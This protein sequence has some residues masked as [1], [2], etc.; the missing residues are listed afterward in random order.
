ME[1]LKQ[2]LSMDI[3]E[4]ASFALSG[5]MIGVKKKL[6]FFG[7]VISGVVTATG[8]GMMRDILLG[9]I[10]PMAFVDPRYVIA[11]AITSA[12]LFLIARIKRE[13]YVARADLVDQ[14]N[15]VVDAL[16]LGAFTVIGVQSVEAAGYGDN[17]FFSIFIGVITA[18]GGGALRD[19]FLN[20][21][22]FILYKRVYMVAS[23]LGAAVYVDLRRLGFDESAATLPVV[24]LV[25]VV[26][27]LAT[28]YHWDFPKAIE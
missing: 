24:I 12:I 23:M 10:P 25:F 6:D 1:I 3:L 22:P 11:A 9:K 15:N 21:M 28:R 18:V 20:E 16:G 2:Y 27:M 5:S 7:V 17:A 26:R 14:I 8:G 13:Q 4:I 19:I